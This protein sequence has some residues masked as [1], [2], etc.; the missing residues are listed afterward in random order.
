[1]STDVSSSSDKIK[2]SDH[3]HKNYLLYQNARIIQKNLVYVIGLSSTLSDKTVSFSL[4][5]F[6]LAKNTSAN[7]VKS[8]NLSS[9]IPKDTSRKEFKVLHTLPI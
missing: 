1:M 4:F 9:I 3:K 7:M 8:L 5:R 2:H 6:F